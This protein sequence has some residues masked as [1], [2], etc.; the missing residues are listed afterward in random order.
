MSASEITATRFTANPCATV[1]LPK[2][3]TTAS[4]ACGWEVAAMDLIMAASEPGCPSSVPCQKPRPG[5]A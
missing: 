5:Q 4:N 2:P 1:K 3:E